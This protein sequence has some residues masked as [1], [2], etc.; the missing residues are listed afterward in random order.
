MRAK[1][2]V[3][4]RSVLRTAALGT[5]GALYAPQLRADAP[6]EAGHLRHSICRWCYGGTP[7]EKLAEGAVKLGYQS[8]ELIGPKE[9]AVIKPYGL[10][11]A[12][13]RCASIADGLNRPE[14]H[15][16]I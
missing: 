10:T 3:D 12:M 9:F 5:L 16:R 13:V 8:I 6:P 1:S 4:R 7:L 14:N 11:C 15:D 2:L